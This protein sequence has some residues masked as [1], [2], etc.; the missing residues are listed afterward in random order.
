MMSGG[1][2]LEW[3]G[4]HILPWILIIMVS[5]LIVA[6]PFGISAWYKDSKRPTFDLKKDDWVCTKFHREASTY[7]IT[8]GKV[9]L[10]QTTTTE[11]CDQ[12]TRKE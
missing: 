8:V 11:V 6:I 5:V 4:L 12:W 3:F 10:P 7:Y 1:D 9:L 2:I